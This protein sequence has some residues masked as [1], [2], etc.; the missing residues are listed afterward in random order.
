[1]SIRNISYLFNSASIAVI[2]QGK[3]GMTQA[4]SQIRHLVKN[5]YRGA[6]LP[7]V[8]NTQVMAGILAYPDL[9][10]LP[11]IPDCALIHA[12]PANWLKIV[13]DLAQKGTKAAV[14]M[15]ADLPLPILSDAL[16]Q[17]LLSAAKPTTMRLLGPMQLGMAAPQNQLNA[18]QWDIALQQ[19]GIALFGH[20][21]A[22]L[23]GIL[24]WA[25]S[26]NIG[27]SHVFSLGERMDID[28]ADMLDYLATDRHSRAIVIVMEQIRKPRKFLSAAR[29]A[30]RI[31]PIVILKPV[32]ADKKEDLVYDAA[33]RRAGI[34]RVRR[35]EE[36][37]AAIETLH[38]IKPVTQDSL[39]IISHDYSWG[40]LTHDALRS[41]GGTPA[42]FTAETI[43]ALQAVLPSNIPLPAITNP[44]I[45][46]DHVPVDAM[47]QALMIIA[48]HRA[49]GGIVFVASAGNAARDRFVADML[50]QVAKKIHI[51][52]LTS[53]V[54]GAYAHAAR[55]ICIRE[56]IPTYSDPDHAVAVFARSA[57]YSLRKQLLMET[58]PSLPEA[59]VVDHQRVRQ[60]IDTAKAANATHLNTVDA[61]QLLA[62]YQINVAPAEYAATPEAARIAALRYPAPF[63]LKLL[64]PGITDRSAM[65]GIRF[66]LDT[67]EQVY[68]AAIALKERLKVYRPESWVTGFVVQPLLL[69]GNAFELNIHVHDTDFGPVIRFGHGGVEA[70]AIDDFAYALPALNLLLAEELVSRTRVY[71][72][73]AAVGGRHAHL[74]SLYMT[75]IKVSQMVV[76]IP[77]LAELSI[78]PLWADKD[79]V[80]VIDARL[81]LDFTRTELASHRFA[82]RPYPKELEQTLVLAGEPTQT[83]L[84]RPI[85]PE[86]EPRLQDMVREAPPEDV[87]LRFFQSLKELPHETAARLT[88]LDYD[89]EMA[90]CVTE[91][92]LPGTKPLYAVV[93]IT[94]EPNLESAEYAIMV[95][96]QLAGQGLGKRLMLHIIDYAKQRHIKE[97]HGEVLAEN[98]SM[99]ALNRKLGFKIKAHPDDNALKV[100]TLTLGNL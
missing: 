34:M 61:L 32:S 84:I 13:E 47:Q 20:S 54:G 93:R 66:G 67:A 36:L 90:F 33:F 6:V 9:N 12:P 31:K 4:E 62:A 63:V 52:L 26:L 21:C 98:T 56:H 8:P 57:R 42:V 100:V 76:D 50:A 77:E 86:D 78:N 27:F 85:L 1:M 49:A 15:C 81:Q 35:I 2:G 37:V 45:L 79:G 75:L 23:R 25:S 97:I 18:L 99:L 60:L 58:P 55:D 72:L 30:A 40:M 41:V 71:A 48:Q 51:P 83:L 3:A 16:I 74:P 59:F 29:V 7:V 11:M 24:D 28:Y 73:L 94:C 5:H 19:G 44:L 46:S 64:S 38:A 68:E 17:S 89:R 82:I 92:G 80:R 87:R 88:Q 70:E 69:R 10:T 91:A 95:S 39:A 65:G 53:W 96:R 43:S 22:V 14:F